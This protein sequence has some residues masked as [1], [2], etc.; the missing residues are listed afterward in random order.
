MP[1]SAGGNCGKCSKPMP[2][3]IEKVARG[4]TI[5]LYMNGATMKSFF[6]NA[7]DMELQFCVRCKTY[8][9][10]APVPSQ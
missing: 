1:K 10:L 8:T 7:G 9:R 6:V 4:S 3:T 2:T 5:P